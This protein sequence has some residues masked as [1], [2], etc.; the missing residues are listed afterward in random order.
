MRPEGHAGFSL[1]VMSASMMFFQY[2]PALGLPII[3]LTVVF[4]V[5]PD[6]DIRTGGFVEH[7]GPLT[8][9]IFGAVVMAVLSGG[10]FL[11]LGFGFW[12]GFIGAFLGVVL[13]LVGDMA[14]FAKFRPFWPLS[15]RRVGLGLFR[16]SDRF[17][18]WA[19]AVLGIV[20]L[21]AYLENG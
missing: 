16:S 4:S 17:V 21:F 15:N 7:R 14:T 6:L 3:A 9:S 10:V 1:A 12:S 2:P 20:A 11:W 19:L 18:N 8:H 5:F 13:H